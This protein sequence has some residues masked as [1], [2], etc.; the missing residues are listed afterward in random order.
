MR[1]RLSAI[2]AEDR[3]RARERVPTDRYSSELTG[4]W[5]DGRP[6]YSYNYANAIHVGGFV[7]RFGRCRLSF[8]GFH[9]TR[10][11]LV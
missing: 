6:K 8:S 11:R 1:D 3:L 9:A 4:R 10:K 5:P 7:E 2:V